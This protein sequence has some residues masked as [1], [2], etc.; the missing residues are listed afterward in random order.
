M[1]S[2][3]NSYYSSTSYPHR[4]SHRR[5]RSATIDGGREER[6]PLRN[7]T[8]GASTARSSG[9]QPSPSP[10]SPSLPPT[11]GTP[12]GSRPPTLPPPS[13]SHPRCASSTPVLLT[14][15][16]NPASLLAA[17]P[18]LS[19]HGDNNTADQSSVEATRD[20]SLEGIR[21]RATQSASLSSPPSRAGEG[22]GRRTQ[23]PVALGIVQPL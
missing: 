12:Y 17:P 21:P 23:R 9:P 19:P 13:S 16:R 6:P 11:P 4:S 2:T 15:T 20:P 3:N 22:E 8:T 18:S 1:L 5:P 7:T 10:A 14:P